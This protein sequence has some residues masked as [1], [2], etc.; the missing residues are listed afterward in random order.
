MQRRPKQVFEDIEAANLAVPTDSKVKQRPYLVTGTS[1]MARYVVAGNP[2]DAAAVYAEVVLGVK[3]RLANSRRPSKM[4]QI[5][6]IVETTEP[7][8]KEARQVLEQLRSILRSEEA[9]GAPDLPQD[10]EPDL[11]DGLPPPPPPI[12]S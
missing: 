9:N 3:A 1:G 10:P 12:Q 8:S 6:Q 5:A 4:S 7:K 2:S 11:P